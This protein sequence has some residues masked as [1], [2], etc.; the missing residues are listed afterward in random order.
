MI[1]LWVLAAAV[2]PRI[3]HKEFALGDA[4]RTEGVRLDDV[5]AGLQKPAMNVAN[6]FWLGQR[7]QVAI[8]E[9]TLGRVLEPLPT[10]IRFLH[11]VGA[12]RRTHRSIDDGD[13]I[14]QDLFQ[15]MRLGFFHVLLMCSGSL[16]FGA[17]LTH[18]PRATFIYYS[19]WPYA[20]LLGRSSLK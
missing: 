1:E 8:V 14:L 15:R 2:L 3:F 10:D 17:D 19:D 4:R 6:H 12:N 11:P 7:E 18:S 9:E 16:R 5:R 13:T 20:Q